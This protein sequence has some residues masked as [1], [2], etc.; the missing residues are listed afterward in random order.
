MLEGKKSIIIDPFLTGNPLAAKKPEE[1]KADYIL[2]SHGHGDHLGDAIEIAKRSGGTIISPNEL[3][4]YCGRK[5]AKVHNMHIGGAYNFDGVKVKLTPAWHGSAVVDDRDI[6]YTGNPCGF[7]IW[8]DDLCIYHAGDTALFGDMDKVIGKYHIIDLALL[9]IGDNFTMGPEDAVIAAGWLGAKTVIPM[10]Y[11]TWP[12]IAQDANLFKE[13]VE[14]QT[15][16]KCVVL[17]PGE[18]IVL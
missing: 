17:K 6:I 1:I 14:A 10:H 16:S 3:A 11:N 9:P 5:G 7:L 2:V 8:V 12:L 18:S 15:T 13:S 4:V